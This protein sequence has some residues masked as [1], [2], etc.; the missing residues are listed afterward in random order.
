MTPR[1]FPLVEREEDS[2]QRSLCNAD[3]G[4]L[5]LDR[6]MVRIRIEGTDENTAAPVREL[7]GVLEKI[8]EDLLQP[9]RISPH[10]VP[11]GCEIAIE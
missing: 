1:K 5:N 9:C 10:I 8:P 2:F 4:I 3:P 6:K 7:H 11:R